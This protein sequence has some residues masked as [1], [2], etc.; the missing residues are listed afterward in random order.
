[1]ANGNEPTK[2]EL[3]DNIDDAVSILTAAYT[4]EATRFDLVSAVSD[5]LDALTGKRRRRYRR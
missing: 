4:P 2:D 1:M 3:Q 5:A